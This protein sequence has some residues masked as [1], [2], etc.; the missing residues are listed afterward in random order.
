VIV[1]YFHF[2]R[3]VIAP[4]KANPVL[5]V[6]ADAALS[7]SISSQL[8]KPIARRILKILQFGGGVQHR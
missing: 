4:H 2:I 8:L 5:V 1:R 3:I 6:N 7:L